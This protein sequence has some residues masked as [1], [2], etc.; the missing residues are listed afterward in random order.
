MINHLI[1]VFILILQEKRRMGT[2]PRTRF[3]M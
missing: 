3:G 2:D 1:I